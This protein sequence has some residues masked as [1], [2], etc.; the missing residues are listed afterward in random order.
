[1]SVI[2]PIA[3]KDM[4]TQWDIKGLTQSANK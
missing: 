4:L 1:M 2:N 3:Q